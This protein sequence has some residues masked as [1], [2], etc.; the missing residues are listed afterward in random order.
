MS[1]ILFIKFVHNFLKSIIFCWWIFLVFITLMILIECLCSI[2]SFLILLLRWFKKIFDVWWNV[3]CLSQRSINFFSI[4]MRS[5]Q[6]VII[7]NRG[8]NSIPKK[9]KIGVI[10]RLKREFTTR[11]IFISVFPTA[12]LPRTIKLMSVSPKARNSRIG[13]LMW[14]WTIFIHGI[15]KKCNINLC[16]FC[17]FIV[18]KSINRSIKNNKLNQI[19]IYRSIINDEWV[20][21]FYF[22]MG[23]KLFFKKITVF[24]FN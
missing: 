23:F 15:L 12:I 10:I 4:R 21:Y 7:D 13:K 19:L 20:N 11:Y 18:I 1:F 9:S 14:L 5:E 2:G 3:H 6:V 16:S 8:P 24:L 17:N 22:L